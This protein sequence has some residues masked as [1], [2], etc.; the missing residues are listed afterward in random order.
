MGIKKHYWNGSKPLTP[1]LELQE[2]QAVNNLGDLGMAMKNP[3]VTVLPG[4]ATTF[5]QRIK[6]GGMV[7]PEITLDQK[8]ESLYKN[9]SI[10][11]TGTISDIN[12]KSYRLYLEMDNK[13]KKHDSFAR[14]CGCSFQ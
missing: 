2:G 9:E 14:L 3:G 5:K 13:N 8:I 7:A 6:F 1:P 4:E 11:I 12:N 10:D